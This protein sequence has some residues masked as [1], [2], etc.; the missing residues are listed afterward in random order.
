[1]ITFRIGSES[2][3]C[4]ILRSWITFSRSLNVSTVRILSENSIFVCIF[5]SF[6]FTYMF[7]MWDFAGEEKGAAF[8]AP[9]YA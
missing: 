9:K 6:L 8:A 4:P 2:S 7:N 1:M 3:S 5:F